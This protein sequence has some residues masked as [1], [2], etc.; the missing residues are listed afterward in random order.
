MDYRDDYE[1]SVLERQ[2]ADAAYLTALE[3]W[4]KA[5]VTYVEGH[6]C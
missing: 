1:Q 6:L 5:L 3:A 4:A 2:R